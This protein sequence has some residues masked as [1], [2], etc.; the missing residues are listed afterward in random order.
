VK[1]FAALILLAGCAGAPTARELLFEEVRAKLADLEPRVMHELMT[2]DPVPYTLAYNDQLDRLAE[3]L[4]VDGVLF[5]TVHDNWAKLD[6][7]EKQFALAHELVHVHG[8]V[9]PFALSEGLA[10]ITACQLVP[11]LSS[12][13]WLDHWVVQASS[14]LDAEDLLRQEP[15]SD[16]EER[17]LRA[18]GFLA[19]YALT[20]EGRVSLLNAPLAPEQLLATRSWSTMQDL[21]IKTSTNRP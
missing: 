9:L 8:P 15:C 19:L 21:L 11:E 5:L 2:A 10:D 13:I 20:P 14:T 16:R 17:E 4:Q 1:Y 12:R 18:L 7:S 6:E 3:V